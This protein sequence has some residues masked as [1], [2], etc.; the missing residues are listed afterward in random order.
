MWTPEMMWN[1]REKVIV[2]LSFLAQL[3][4]TVPTRINVLLISMNLERHGYSL[5]FSASFL[6]SI[7]VTE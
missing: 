3:L 5:E 7:I 6:F 1:Y 2:L 4:P